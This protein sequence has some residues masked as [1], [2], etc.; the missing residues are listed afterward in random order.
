MA[1]NTQPLIIKPEKKRA[2]DEVVDLKTT[3]MHQCTPPIT[4]DASSQLKQVCSYLPK[5]SHL[6]NDFIVDAPPFS[7]W[8][9]SFLT[10]QKRDELLKSSCD[11]DMF[12]AVGAI[13]M[14]QW[15]QAANY[16]VGGVV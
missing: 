7:L 8:C 1:S 11:I 6:L 3:L 12:E 2:L 16:R 15:I 13:G 10:Q 5:H 14:Y 9:L 4:V